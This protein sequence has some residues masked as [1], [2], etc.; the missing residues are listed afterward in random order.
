METINN[1]VFL[2]GT[3]SNIKHFLY[4]Y[5][6]TIATTIDLG[7]YNAFHSFMMYIY[8]NDLYICG[9]YTTA[10]T[11]GILYY[12]QK[13]DGSTCQHITP[14]V[15]SIGLTRATEIKAFSVY[16]N[17][18]FFVTHD[19]YMNRNTDYIDRYYENELKP[20]GNDIDGP[21]T[22]DSITR[23]FIDSENQLYAFKGDKAYR[24]Q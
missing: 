24:L 2:G 11:I 12:L 1:E 21:S 16:D 10:E 19:S 22:E 18:Y 23:F 5:N 13:Y 3:I 20:V 17:E 9:D 15:S 8:N 6:G 4:K 14:K 7:Q